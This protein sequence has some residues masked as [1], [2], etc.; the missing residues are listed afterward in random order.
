LEIE[1]RVSKLEENPETYKEAQ[2]IKRALTRMEQEFDLTDKEKEQ[3]SDSYYE[4]KQDEESIIRFQ[5]LPA[6]KQL[7]ARRLMKKG[8]SLSD[9]IDKVEGDEHGDKTR[10]N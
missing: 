6:Y 4:M 7:Q 8:V 9:A 5:I 10:K 1:D 2:K 3:I